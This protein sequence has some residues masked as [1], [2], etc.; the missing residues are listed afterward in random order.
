MMQRLQLIQCGTVYVFTKIQTA[1][2]KAKQ[3]ITET[4]VKTIWAM[5]S[6]MLYRYRCYDM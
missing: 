1:W 3:F 5:I 6:T 4:T 2:A